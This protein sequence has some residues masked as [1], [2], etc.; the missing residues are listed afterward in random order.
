M[1]K[2][3]AHPGPAETTR[4]P[5]HRSLAMG[6]SCSPGWAQALTDVCTTAAGLPEEARVHPDRPS[7][8]CL[9]VW[10]SIMDDLWALELKD[11]RDPPEEGPRWMARAA[12]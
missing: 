6:F 9:P 2:W 8:E 5:C 7:P 11:Y 3:L 4:L 1:G 10:A 12:G